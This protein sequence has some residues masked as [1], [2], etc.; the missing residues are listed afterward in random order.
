MSAIHFQGC[1]I[2]Q[3]SCYTLLSG[4][5]LP[6]PPSC[7][8]DEATPFLGSDERVFRHLNSAFGSS[9]IASSAYQKWP[10]KNSSHDIQAQLSSPRCP[11][12]LKFESRTRKL[13]PR[14]LQ[15]LAL[16]DCAVYMSSSYPEGNFGR[17]QLLDGSMSL[18]PLS[19]SLTNDLHVS[20]ATVLHQSFLWLQ[21]TQA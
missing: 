17:N 20:I 9:R 21:P 6:W 12:D 13:L 14:K 15:S 8:L 19:S 3:V 10:T 16:P 4:Y 5:R 2:R 7:C 11:A 1:F 18:S